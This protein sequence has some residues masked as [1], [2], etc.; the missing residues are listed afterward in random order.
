MKKQLFYSI[1]AHKCPIILS[2]KNN[3]YNFYHVF[4]TGYTPG[5]VLGTLCTMPE[6]LQISLKIL[7]SNYWNGNWCLK[8]LNLSGVTAWPGYILNAMF[9][10]PCR[11]ECLLHSQSHN[12][13]KILLAFSEDH[14]VFHFWKALKNTPLGK[15]K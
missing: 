15:E 14:R 11:G 9:F 13:K 5:T 7:A 10:L 1:N 3:N 8:K 6:F 4:S 12:F 2:Y